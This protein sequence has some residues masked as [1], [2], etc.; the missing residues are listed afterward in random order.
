MMQCVVAVFVILALLQ[1]IIKT[2]HGKQKNRA[3]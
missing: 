3:N 1:A 2:E